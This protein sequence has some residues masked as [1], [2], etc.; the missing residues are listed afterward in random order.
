MSV[1]VFW[2]DKDGETRSYHCGDDLQ[3]ALSTTEELRRHPANNTHVCISSENS[4]S[5]GPSGVTSVENGVLP[6][7][8]AYEWR[9]RR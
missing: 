4:D 9:K 7:G 6:N 3:L 8:D 1:V 5:V 2:I